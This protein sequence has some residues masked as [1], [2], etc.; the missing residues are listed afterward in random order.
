M[1]ISSDCVPIGRGRVGYCR[2]SRVADALVLS[3]ASIGESP[4]IMPGLAQV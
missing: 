3:P 2:S 4:S 1:R